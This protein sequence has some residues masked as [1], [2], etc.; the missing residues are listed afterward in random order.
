M[1]RL[2]A[3]LLCAAIPLTTSAG[4]GSLDNVLSQ[5]PE[6][7]R[8]RYSERHPSE[9]LDFFG[10]E[11]GMTVVEAL[12]G[13]GWYSKILLP[14]LGEGGK[15]VGADYNP[16]MYALF[17]FMTPERLKEKETWVADWTSDAGDWA[18]G[19]GA[20]VD[21]FVFGELPEAMHGSAD[22]VLFVRALHN[23]ARFNAQGSHLDKAISDTWYL[24]KPGGVLGVVQHEARPGMPD[25]W[26]D[27]SRGYLKQSF[28]V[29]KLEAAGFELQDSSDINANAKDRPAEDDVVWRLPPSLVTSQD[30]PELQAEL[31]EV[32]ESNR[33][34]LLFR[35]PG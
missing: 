16:A 26:A 14:Y 20:S 3:P 23:L 21:A 32:G 30:D 17:G 22:A 28:L 7:V 13:G 29:E 12:P 8:A 15:L 34:T 27:G 33:M 18:Q 4:S 35:K 10:I 25:N 6:E 5:Q 24:L 2:L 9:T 11:P 19:T 31:R 1:R